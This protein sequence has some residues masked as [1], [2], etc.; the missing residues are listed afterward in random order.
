MP[1]SFETLLFSSRVRVAKVRM[2]MAFCLESEWHRRTPGQ[3]NILVKK[4]ILGY[5]SKSY[6]VF[7]KILETVLYMPAKCKNNRW[8]IA[9]CE[10]ILLNFFRFNNTGY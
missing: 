4:P 7:K 3:T 5:V 1:S 2:A 8:F 10:D 9:M 6:S